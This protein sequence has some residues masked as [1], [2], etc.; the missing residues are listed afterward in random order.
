MGVATRQM[1]L[2]NKIY[3]DGECSYCGK[4]FHK[5]YHTE[6][7]CSD[8]CREKAV[9][10][11]KLRYDQQNR[12]VDDEIIVN[13]SYCGK[14]FTRKHNSQIYCS[15][16]CK[17]YAI[18]ETHAEYQRSRRKSLRNKELVSNENNYVGTNYLSGKRRED[19]DDEQAAILKEMKRL[20]LR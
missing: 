6:K 12:K 8:D 16:V 14:P 13:C 20:K 17:N 4:K 10:A 7:Y 5:K 18:M 11:Q 15:D 1:T 19:F 3:Y 9:H 2:D